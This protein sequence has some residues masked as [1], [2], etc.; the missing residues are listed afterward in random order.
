MAR[1]HT[2]EEE[3]EAAVVKKGRRRRGR[4]R[5]S[6]K[7]LRPS[8][9]LTDEEEEER[10]AKFA[11]LQEM[12]KEL[13]KSKTPLDL[14]LAIARAHVDLDMHSLS[15]PFFRSST[16][17]LPY[18]P[19]F[20]PRAVLTAAARKLERM[21]KPQRER[22]LLELAA[23]EE[24]VRGE[25]FEKQRLRVMAAHYEIGAAHL[26]TKEAEA[27]SFHFRAWRGM[28]GGGEEEA[29]EVRVEL[30][31]LLSRY[32][33][34]ADLGAG[35]KWKDEGYSETVMHCDRSLGSLRDLHIEVLEHLLERS[36]RDQVVLKRLARLYCLLRKFERAQVLWEV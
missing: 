21:G 34:L 30:D 29:R 28:E 4:E 20:V 16:K 11:R 15:I 36:P 27:A 13:G 12:K 25:F 19:P 10:G 3:E 5:N 17:V 24:R 26:E 23:A 32:H 35:G 22:H 2:E 14:S 8:A 9:A 18:S 1:M 6:H 31:R 7:A 33:D